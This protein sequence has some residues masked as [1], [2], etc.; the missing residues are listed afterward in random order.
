MDAVLAA[1]Q[2]A[3]GLEHV[4][5]LEPDGGEPIGDRGQK[6][7]AVDQVEQDRLGP[8]VLLNVVPQGEPS[9]PPSQD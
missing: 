7:G 6:L 8:A 1:A 2:Q 5:L 9:S 4:E 3:L